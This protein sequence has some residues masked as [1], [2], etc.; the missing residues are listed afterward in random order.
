[1]K[2]ELQRGGL[3]WDAASNCPKMENITAF[4]YITG[5][6]CSG[7]HLE[8]LGPK[9]NEG[10]PEDR[11]MSGGV[12]SQYRVE[13]Y[14]SILMLSE[15]GKAAGMSADSRVMVSML[16]MRHLQDV[17]GV[18]SRILVTEIRDPRT[19]E[20]MSLTKCSDSVV[21]NE[22]VAMILA[23][24]SEDRDIGYV[25]EDLFSEEGMEM[26]IKDIRLFVA[27]DELLSWWD[28]VGRCQQRNMLPIGWIRKNGDPDAEIEAVINP[29]PDNGHDKNEPM[30]WNGQEW[31]FG[32]MLIVISLD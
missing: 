22:L 9:Q 18:Q 8:R 20:L 7:K 19:Q 6:P 31:P 25:M 23:Q 3:E 10:E 30:R 2:V 1:M 11:M 27:P 15:E 24:I 29:G 26:H 12:P 17:R 32:D 14:D 4:E 21:G 16:V 5:D 13:N 28:L